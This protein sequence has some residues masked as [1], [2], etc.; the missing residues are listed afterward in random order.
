MKELLQELTY[1]FNTK[2][3]QGEDTKS[4]SPWFDQLT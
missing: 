2:Y 4:S 1:F 3:N